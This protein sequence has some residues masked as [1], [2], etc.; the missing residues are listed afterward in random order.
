MIS[1][2][3][4]EKAEN[5]CATKITMPLIAETKIVEKKI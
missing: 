3:H 4:R 1:R 5:N 2:M